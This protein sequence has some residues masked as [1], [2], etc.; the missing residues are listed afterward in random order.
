MTC[1]TTRHRLLHCERPDRPPAD[2][3]PHLAEC[4][5]CRAWQ[6]RLTRVEQQLGEAPV[7]SSAPPADLMRQ[8]LQGPPP[9]PARSSDQNSLSGGGAPWWVAHP[10]ADRGLAP[11]VDRTRPDAARRLGDRGRQKVALAF[12]L[13]LG[14]A[15]FSLCWGLCSHNPADKIATQ[16]AQE[17]R[18]TRFEMRYL[19]ARTPKERVHLLA[20]YADELQRTARGLADNPDTGDLRAVA[21]LY[22]R[23]VR[24]RL[25]D[26]ARALAR[27][28]RDVVKTIVARLEAIE[29]PLEQLS[30]QAAVAAR[31]PLGDMAQATRYGRARLLELLRDA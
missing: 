27:E 12:A 15:V 31:A 21:A 5:A 16:V 3:Q 25:P 29:S 6:R 23:I 7:P 19:L 9:L 17:D 2:V 11:I 22:S 24:D 10:N 1:E 8:I 18:A 4:A 14:L 28:D 13:T 30:G 26:D 20:D